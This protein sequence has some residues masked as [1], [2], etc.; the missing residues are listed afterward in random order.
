MRPWLSTSA[1]H[2]ADS[3]IRLKAR[4]SVLSVIGSVSSFAASASHASSG[5][6][7][8]HRSNPCVKMKSAP[9]FFSRKR[10]GKKSRFL[11]SKPCSYCPKNLDA[12]L[13]PT[14]L[15][16]A[17]V[18][19]RCVYL[20]TG[21]RKKIPRHLS[22]EDRE[23]ESCILYTE[24]CSA[25]AIKRRRERHSSRRRPRVRTSRASSPRNPLTTTSHITP[26]T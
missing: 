23:N 22:T 15:H 4:S 24:F 1:S 9:R 10:D 2:A 26:N 12:L 3:K 17:P 8:R 20:S 5:K 21:G 25:F 14:L 13:F 7:K 16:R 6:R 18:Y 11:P 19:P